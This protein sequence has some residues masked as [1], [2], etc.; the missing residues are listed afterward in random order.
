MLRFA[1][2]RDRINILNKNSHVASVLHASTDSLFGYATKV[3]ERRKMKK[4]FFT[5]ALIVMLVFAVTA[6]NGNGGD[7]DHV[8]SYGEWTTIK[9]A[10]CTEDGSRERVCS[11]AEKETET[12]PAKGHSFGDWVELKE[13]ACVEDGIKI[14]VCACGQQETENI[15]AN[16]HSFDQKNTASE[17]V[18]SD[19]TCTEVAVY[20]YSCACGEKGTT[21][22]T[23]GTV[24]ANTF[25][26]RNTAS[27]Y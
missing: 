5:L 6:C 11:C 13:P 24:E 26:Q 9:E 19:A 22:F 16:G 18:K 8:H 17:Y 1:V 23:S 12:I 7:T 3:E 21:T 2:C 15:A 20:Y 27:K 10:T 4:L 14:R 25:D